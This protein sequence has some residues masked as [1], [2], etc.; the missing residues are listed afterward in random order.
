MRVRP[1]AWLPAISVV[2]TTV[3]AK[4]QTSQLAMFMGCGSARPDARAQR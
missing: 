4:P 1:S 2:S 3:L